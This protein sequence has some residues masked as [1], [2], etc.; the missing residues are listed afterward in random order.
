MRKSLCRL[1]FFAVLF[2][3]LQGA[4]CPQVPDM[5]DTEVTVVA[6][7]YVE[8][9]FLARGSINTHSDNDTINI[10]ELRD[11]IEDAGIDLG[12]IDSAWVTRVLYGVI[13]YNE[14]PHD[15]AIANGRVVVNREDTAQSAT[16]FDNVNVDV[17]PLLGTLEPAPIESG[18]IEFL[19][20]LLADVLTALK[21]YTVDEFI[22]SAE[23]SGDSNP[24]DRDT[25]FDWRVR[26]YYQI[27]GS[28]TIEVPQLD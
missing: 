4:Q 2:I 14:G 12:A 10:A 18:G 19:N 25:N 15:R 17:Y 9:V 22:I 28:D 21:D 11:E 26:I 24:Q 27:V 5:T 3:V 13:A 23:S 1:A 6:D 20:D 8:L 16:L 7:D